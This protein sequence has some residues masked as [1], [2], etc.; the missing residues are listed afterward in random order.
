MWYAEAVQETRFSEGKSSE[1]IENEDWFF[2]IWGN[3]FFRRGFIRR[4][5][6]LEHL[7]KTDGD[8]RGR[9]H[10]SRGRNDDSSTPLQT[11]RH[12]NSRSVYVCI[13][14]LLAINHWRII[15]L[16]VSA[17]GRR[18]WRTRLYSIGWC[19]PMGYGGH[20]YSYNCINEELSRYVQVECVTE[21]RTYLKFWMKYLLGFLSVSFLLY[22]VYLLSFS[23][24]FKVW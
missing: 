2:C 19:S 20:F 16:L 7:L 15:V 17:T 8:R 23:F 1:D 14:S 12:R 9:V 11:C 24:F 4:T 13:S 6:T 3:Y 5:R 18:K 10:P 22:S 21:N